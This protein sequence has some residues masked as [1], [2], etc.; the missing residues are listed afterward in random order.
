M[1]RLTA[2]QNRQTT[3]QSELTNRPTEQLNLASEHNSRQNL[4]A[5]IFS[6]SFSGQRVDGIH[7]QTV[8]I[9][10]LPQPSAFHLP[11]KEDVV[12]RMAASGVLQLT[13]FRPRPMKGNAGP[14]EKR[15][16]SLSETLMKLAAEP[17]PFEGM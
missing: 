17:L 16:G 3:V 1:P 5:Y 14:K 13:C 2:G 12:E 15:K 11:F 8:H 6:F 7:T 4:S 10:I 9:M